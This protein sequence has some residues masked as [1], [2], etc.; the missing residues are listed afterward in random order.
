MLV[1][2]HTG[3]KGAWLVIWLNNLGAE[4]HGLALPPEAAPNLH[5]ASGASKLSDG[6]FCDVRHRDQ[7]A[8]SIQKVAPEIVFHLAAQAL[9]M[10]GYE[11]PVE[12]FETNV[13]G[14]TNVL[15]AVRVAGQCRVAIVA[16]TDK[17]YENLE[18]VKPFA[19][20]DKL[21]GHDP[22]SASKA[23][24]EIVAAS[25]RSS[26]FA[27]NTALAT[28]RAGNVIGGG[29][30]AEHRL[31]PDAVR[32]WSS[33]QKLVLRNPA[34]VRPWQHV[35][36]PLAGYL[37]LA[38]LAWDNP[39]LASAYNIGPDLDDVAT[40]DAVVLL[41]R[42]SFG[43]G[44]FM[45]SNAGNTKKEASHLALDNSKAKRDLGIG[46]RWRL[47]TAVRKTMDWYR[48]FNAGAPALQLCQADIADYVKTP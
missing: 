6:A 12:T 24:A 15:D 7:V 26:F 28:V 47:E 9:V 14:T 29:D 22:Y 17:V 27:G 46:P 18:M 11:Q 35:L 25:Y 44:E 45:F 39:A 33:S 42:Q 43:G 20:E 5:D 2:G 32:A 41:A 10:R 34:S 3:F 8:A 30:W 31:I 1:T 13:L 38:E 4:V 23:A 36:E 19:E 21:G 40:V 37:V 16:T 48:Q